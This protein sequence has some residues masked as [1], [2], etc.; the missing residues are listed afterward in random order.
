MTEKQQQVYSEAIE[1][2]R[3]KKVKIVKIVGESH[4]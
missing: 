2:E 1:V 3:V 4:L